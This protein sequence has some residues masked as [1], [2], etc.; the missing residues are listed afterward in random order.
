MADI[1]HEF[2]FAF[3]VS[4]TS[5]GLDSILSGLDV[6]IY[7]EGDDLNLNPLFG[8]KGIKF[9]SNAKELASILKER[10]NLEPLPKVDEFFWLDDQFPRWSRLLSDSG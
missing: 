2:D 4:E 6:A 8:V 3:S 1:L 10:K 7:L 9:I 5:A